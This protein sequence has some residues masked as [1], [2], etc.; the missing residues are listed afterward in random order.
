MALKFSEGQKLAINTKE[1]NILVSAAAGSGKTFVLT[2]RVLARII[3]D[4]WDIDSFLIVTFTR[5]AAAEMKERIRSSVEKKLNEITKE[6]NIDEDLREHL[7]KQ[8]ILIDRANISTI[9]S[10]CSSVIRQNFHKVDL[11]LGYKNITQIEAT[12]LKKQAINEVLESFLEENDKEFVSFYNMF[13]ERNSD[14][15]VV[16]MVY[17]LYN[18]ADNSPY[19]EKWL[20]ECKKKYED[21]DNFYDS[22]WGKVY[23]ENIKNSINYA[24]EYVDEAMTYFKN[25]NDI[26]NVI[27]KIYGVIEDFENAFKTGGIKEVAK[28]EIKFNITMPKSIDGFGE[29]R[30]NLVK[31]Y[32]YFAK[33][34]LSSA[35]EKASLPEE[36]VNFFFNNIK[37]GVRALVKVTKAFIKKY[38][39]L[40]IENQLAD[41]NDI[42]HYCLGIL[43]NDDG[44]TTET[45]KEYQNKYKEII[46]DEYQDSNYLQEDILTAVSK[47]EKGENN[48][49]MVGDVKQAIYKFRLT[50]P[51]IFMDKYN[52]YSDHNEDEKLILLSEN[53]RSRA[54]VL[55]ACNL[56]FRQIMD[57]RLGNVEYT[58]AVALNPKAYFPEAPEGVNISKSTEVLIVDTANV[59]S[60]EADC[61]I[62]PRTGEAKVVAKRIY[63][64]LYTNPL[65]I[66]D[67][68]EEK[69]RAVKRKDIVIL[70]RKR[71]NA[72]LF[73]DELNS[74][75]ISCVF[76][77]TSP[78]F[79]T[80]EVKDIISL[81]RIID[82]PLQDIE[83]VNVLHSPMYCLSF[84]DITEIRLNNR[85]ESIF[86]AVKN[87]VDGDEKIS[88][89]AGKFLYDV[90]YY[91]DYAINNSITDLITEIY[92][93]S[94]YFNYVGILE[95]GN[96]R[97]SNLRLFKEQAMEFE[98]V[99]AMDLHSFIQYIDTDLSDDVADKD[100]VGVA[101]NLS[102][103][104][105]VV[106]IMTIHK[107]K[108][109][110]F[111]V[112]FVSQLQDE[113][114]VK[115]KENYIFDRELGIGLKFVDQLN[116]IRYKTMPFDII[117][118]KYKEDEK[119][120][121]LRLLYV[122][123]TRA[124]EK[125]IITGVTNSRSSKSKDSKNA[126]LND[127]TEDRNMLL[128]YAYRNMADCP[129][130][131]VISALKRIEIDKEKIIKQK[132][133]C[134]ENVDNLNDLKAEAAINIISKINDIENSNVENQYTDLINERLNYK[135]SYMTEIEL[136]S[137][138]SITE[139]KRKM[140]LENDEKGIQYYKSEIKG[141][142]KFM[143][144]KKGIT[145]AQIGTLYHT[146]M[147]NMDFRRYK[148]RDDVVTLIENL[149]NRNIITEDE[150]RAINIDKITQFVCS[151]L[152]RRIKCSDGIFTEVPFVMSIKAS[153][154][155]EYK[156]TDANIVVHGIIDL[157]FE[158]GNELVIVDYKTD[159]I[160][161][162][163][164]ELADKYKIQL[165]LYKE[166][167]EKSTGK[168]VKE[169]LIYS[170]DK[171][172]NINV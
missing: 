135:Y 81:L 115:Y 15:G 88:K 171:G 133:V 54:V 169:C 164:S 22:V 51:K 167:L 11:D 42:S 8:L 131:W 129:L 90:N 136:P 132:W 6:E 107:S 91:R 161:K 46:I 30:I 120:E 111:P 41:F 165:Q 32:L 127:L 168:R 28:Q 39:E 154:L 86:Q 145:S 83:V 71:N 62:D 53:Y 50:T 157:Y 47:L 138:I 65:Y 64:M 170:I 58:D 1:K 16:N 158:E 119:S 166:A 149:I 79:K 117:A 148:N 49:F 124:R 109:L 162:S 144:N 5:D 143:K 21:A 56:I 172:E 36:K 142:P 82:N 24:W 140:N 74:M 23:I 139:I 100:K 43:R 123:L 80:T 48:I 57:N 60:G 118:E 146:V 94:N 112:V 96:I 61:D 121:T 66:Y 31:R 38:N 13:M 126:I 159:R 34:E 150:K 25:R 98:S 76:E 108:G 85:E 102:E 7:E 19:P 134:L 63:E 147:E 99:S 105:D 14:N 72:V 156:D 101:A 12:E 73:Y 116:R 84:D 163:V 9:D 68:D 67:K 26:P 3:E 104:E 122:A 2:Q 27:S 128:P 37:P 20:D 125:L 152:F 97:Q 89:V 153:R 141:L 4:R 35:K 87:L 33:K 114:N 75:G 44:S 69:Y 17:N 110:E 151:D 106:R 113:I 52:R 18:Y 95:N 78:L 40:K 29:E 10:F 160:K 77:R 70:V 155:R 55:D 59:K 103:N 93:R 130:F 137:K 92:N 45:A